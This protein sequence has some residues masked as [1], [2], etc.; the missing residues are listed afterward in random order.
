VIV[1]VATRVRCLAA[2]GCCPCGYAVGGARC[3]WCDE[4]APGHAPEPRYP[5][6]NAAPIF[7]R[8]SV[9]PPGSVRWTVTTGEAL[10]EAFGA[11]V[12]S[13]S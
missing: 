1:D 13:P 9:L 3:P 10:R 11:V 5:R 8:F 7:G 12:G 2:C 6:T 4:G